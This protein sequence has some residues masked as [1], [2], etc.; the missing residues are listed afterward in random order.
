MQRNPALMKRYISGLLAV[1][2][3]LHFL[4]ATKDFYSLYVI[5]VA[6]GIEENHGVPIRKLLDV[7]DGR[8]VDYYNLIAYCLK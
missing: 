2:N 5:V 4:N 8:F 3:L 1:K 7:G 6:Y